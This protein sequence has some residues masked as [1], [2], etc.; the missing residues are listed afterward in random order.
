MTAAVGLLVALAVWC[1][2]DP[3]GR[4]ASVAVRGDVAGTRGAGAGGVRV[5]GARPGEAGRDARTRSRRRDGPAEAE[6]VRLVVSQVGALLRAGQPPGAAWERTT[7]ARVDATGTPRTADL[8]VHVGGAATARAVVAAC[9]LAGDVGAPLAT[10]LDEVAASIAAEAEARAARDA[11][12]AGPRATT[13]VLLWL[14][15]VGVL[16]G[17]VLGADPVATALDGG[18][19]TVGVLLGVLL[20]AVGR[21]WSA[22]LVDRARA[23]GEDA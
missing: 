5:G 13:R 10:V 7:G 2:V 17:Y 21:A 15:A 19:G 8:A 11:A 23:A 3:G 6:A 16:L 1:A 14:P 20:L 18:I 22:R 4:R 12:L 9:R